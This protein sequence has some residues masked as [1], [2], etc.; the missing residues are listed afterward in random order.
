MARLISENR[1]LW[2][3]NAD[4]RPRRK[5]FV[6]ELTSEQTGYSSII[7]RDVY[8]R[9]GTADIDAL[10]GNRVMD[11]PKPVALLEELV[12]QANVDSDEIIMDFFAGSGTTAHAV[13]KLNASD[14]KNRRFIMI[15]LPQECDEKSEAAKEGYE[16]ISD[17]SK[18]RIR[19]AGK[20]CVDASPDKSRHLDIGFRVL[21]CDTSN[22]SEVYYSPDALSRENLELFVDN[23]KADRGSEDLLFQVML[24]CGVDLALPIAKKIIQGKEALFI[25]DNALIAC[26]DAQS[27]I[28]E[29]FVKELAKYQPLRVVFRDAGFKDSAVKINVEQIFKSLSPSTE[30]KCI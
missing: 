1:V 5:A 2:P 13:M 22:M 24:D 4:G 26:F 8:T 3:A 25:D 29:D 20:A 16:T 17:L 23:I 7:G 21:R 6:E 14:G 9:N 15:Q 28:D 27:G 18:E 30:V 10:F 11:F 19:R 12:K